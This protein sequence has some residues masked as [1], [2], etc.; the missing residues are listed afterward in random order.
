MFAGLQP[1]VNE[2]IAP[3]GN[4]IPPTGAGEIATPEANGN[5]GAG[6]LPEA[7][8]EANGP[9]PQENVVGEPEN[10]NN[11]TYYHGSKE[12][13]DTFG[14]VRHAATR[15]GRKTSVSPITKSGRGQIYLTQDQ[16]YAS[17]FGDK[18]K[19]FKVPNAKLFSFEELGNKDVSAD[20]LNQILSAHGIEYS[21]KGEARP[22]FEWLKYGDLKKP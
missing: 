1:Q 14:T 9:A 22:V 7:Q 18:V 10:L 19:G 20:E 12:D 2:P 3:A 13:F 8:P 15:Q 16:E 17:T 21:A 5:L 6:V 11:P 4:P